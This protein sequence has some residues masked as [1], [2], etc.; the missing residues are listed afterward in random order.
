MKHFIPKDFEAPINLETDIFH[1]CPLDTNV[2]NLDYE[3][4]MSST[5]EL[6]GIFGRD[7]SWPK[8]NMTL[9]ESIT[10]LKVHEQEFKTKKAFAYS[11]LN[12][13][14]NK[15]FGSIYIDPSRSK[16][17]DCEVYYWIR[18]D[19]IVLQE[20]LFNVVSKWLKSQW[21][22]QKVA[23]PGRLIPWE[24]WDKQVKVV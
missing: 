23:Y 24:N 22:F 5:T 19:S 18:S 1:I 2:A 21:P 17:F 14:R 8:P 4:V 20:K 16:Q 9:E 10:S 11:V 3:A 12:T 15:C 7:F 13:D 6:Q